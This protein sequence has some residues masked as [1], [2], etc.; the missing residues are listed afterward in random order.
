MENASKALVIA[1]GVLIA[2][3]LVGL[4]LYAR[5][6]ISE[7]QNSKLELDRVENV[8]KFNEQFSQYDRKDVAG[9]E[10][11]SLANKV[12]DY[13]FRYS[14]NGINNEGYNQIKMEIS[15]KNEANLRL[16][17]Y[18]TDKNNLF[19]QI[20]Y[21]QDSTSNKII[22]LIKTNFACEENYGG[23][24]VISRIAKN[25][26]SIFLNS[27]NLAQKKQALKQFYE[28]VPKDI[29]KNKL[30]LTDI[31]ETT[32]DK[33]YNE[34][35]TKNIGSGRTIKTDAYKYYE[36]I[37]FKRCIFECKEM[38]YDKDTGRIN[39]IMYEFVRIR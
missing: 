5:S 2:I 3:M 20:T 7:Y 34:L 8:S 18:E 26:N 10:I 13:N 15:L 16:L 37:Q 39:Y 24:E 27:P 33:A 28:I 21:T 32:V 23:E 38:L 1:G 9:Y 35:L 30:G 25:I 6:S 36:Y 4:I 12:A 19:T 22:E 29:R 11:I 31:S 17:S 14:N